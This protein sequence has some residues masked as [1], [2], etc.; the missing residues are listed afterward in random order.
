LL[1]A[2]YVAVS[3][4]ASKL[5]ILAGGVAGVC[6]VIYLMFRWIDWDVDLEHGRWHRVHLCP[7]LRGATKFWW[8][9]R[10]G[11]HVPVCKHC[12]NDLP[13]E[14]TVARKHY[15]WTLVWEER[16]P[17][18]QQTDREFAKKAGIRL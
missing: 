5:L 16:K 13:E 4:T 2:E 3:E 12:G 6:F 14:E 1:V 8:L 15:P 7:C 9:E 11:N 17:V 18:G 10:E